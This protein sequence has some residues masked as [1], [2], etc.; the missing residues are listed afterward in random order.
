MSIPLIIH[1]THEA[2]AKI[3]GIGAVLD[4]ML[5]CTTYLKN[6]ER[7]ILVGPMYAADSSFME[8][9]MAKRNGLTIQYSSM[10]GIFDQVEVG[11]RNA[12]QGIEQTYEVAVLY[13]VR[14]FGDVS[15]EIILVDASAASIAAT[16][17]FFYHIWQHYGLEGF[18]QDWNPE[19]RYHFAIAQPI[20]AVLKALGVDDGLLPEEKIILAHEWIGMPIV[21]AA[22]T[23]EPEQW[24]TV[25]YAHEMAT[26]RRLIEDHSGHDTRFYTAKWVARSHGWDLEQT[27]GNQDAYYKHA[28]IKQTTKC[29]SVLAVGDLVVEELRFVGEA[30]ENAEIYLAYNGV[31]AHT[32]SLD[33]KLESKRRLQEYCQNLLGYEPDFIFTHVTRFVPS[34]ALWRDARVLW[35]LNDYFAELGQHAVLYVLS[36]VEPSGRTA[37]AV[38]A[39]E[40]DYGWPIGHRG[41]NGDLIGDEAAYFFDVVEPFNQAATNCRIIFVN[42]FGWSQ[43]RC[44]IRMPAEMEF[45]DIRRGTDLEFGQSIYEPFGIAQ[46]ESLSFGALC[47]VS[48]VCGCVG[49]VRQAAEQALQ[50]G[51]IETLP[52]TSGLSAE[53]IGPLIIADYVTPLHDQYFADPHA[54][55]SIDHHFRDAIELERAKAVADTITKLL[56]TSAE[57]MDH[58]LS[59]GQSIAQ[60]MSWEVVVKDYV[61]PALS[62][63][64]PVLEE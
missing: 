14:Q 51:D 43:D 56:P 24:H 25:F 62:G 47:C 42:Q 19:Y 20:F 54:A 39:W 30:M 13:G 28:I 44:G 4:G 46:V 8:R 52:L 57:D 50:D 38:H 21:F 41:D 33:Q 55:L 64:M 40:K 11:V 53:T 31:T 49:F 32:I 23:N 35:H 48:N 15:H 58:L 9:M 1:A 37:A 26:A 61:L 12:L 2:G 27:F 36:T 17:D 16:A 5:C 34:K 3:G 6:V 63:S 18:H 45:L 59:I 60:N 10:H 29:N 22:Q 7:T